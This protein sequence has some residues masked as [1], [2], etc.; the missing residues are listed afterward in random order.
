MDISQENPCP[1]SEPELGGLRPHPSLT[2]DIHQGGK[3][4]DRNLPVVL[5]LGDH[6]RSPKT[7]PLEA[8]VLLA[9]LTLIDL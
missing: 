7:L 3:K 9:H 8:A 6:G 2:L 4:V 1:R 5:Q